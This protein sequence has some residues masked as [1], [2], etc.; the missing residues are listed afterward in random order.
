[1]TKTELVSAIQDKIGLSKKESYDIVEKIFE[2][3]KTNL[4]T[5]GHI[6]ISGFGTF[7]VKK[8]HERRGRDPQ[9]GNPLTISGRNVLKFK[10]SPVL[11][12]EMNK[13]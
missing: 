1:M 9:T 5:G 2:M 3:I 8:K 11:K 6:K 10:P 13:V 4:V 12:G 7:E